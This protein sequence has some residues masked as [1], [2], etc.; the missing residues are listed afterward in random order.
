LKTSNFKI[1]LQCKP[2]LLCTL[3]PA[4]PILS[5]CA[6]Q[7]VNSGRFQGQTV[8]IIQ[9]PLIKPAPP[10]YQQPARKLSPEQIQLQLQATDALIKAGNNNAAQKFAEAL[11]PAT[12]SPRQRDQLNLF[13]A[14]I[15][16][17]TGE[18]EQALNRLEL[19][20]A[21]QLNLDNKIK[22]FQ[23]QAF[24]FSLT[25]HLLNSVRSRIEL[26]KLLSSPDERDDNQAAIIETLKLMPESALH[27]Q[28]HTAKDV[29]SGWLSLAGLLKLKERDPISFNVKLAKWR[30]TFPGHP[31]NSYLLK[32]M[33]DSMTSHLVSIAVLL[34]ESGPF[35]Q[36]A[37]AIRAGI[38]AAYT[39][40]DSNAAKPA[41]RFYDTEYSTAD[42]LYHQAVADGAELIIGPLRKEH[43]QSLADSV[44]FDIPVLALNH[45]EGLQKNNLYQ[46]SLSP[47]DDVEQI[48]RKA[49]HDG[50]QKALL[51]IPETVQGKRIADYFTEYWQDFDHSILESQTY[52][53]K[54]TDF[55]SAIKKLLNLDESENRYNRLRQLI[56]P[57]N[58][59]PRRR[60]DADVILLSAY[61]NEA[62]LINPQLHYYQAADLPVYALPAIYTGQP[63]PSLD[64]DLNKIT[65]CDTPWLLGSDQGKLSMS[66]LHDTWRQF[67]SSYLR[68]IAMGID[69]YNLITQLD[70]IDVIPYT[71]A[72]GTLSLMLDGRIKRELVCARFTE[73]RPEIM[74]IPTNSPDTSFTHED[75]PIQEALPITEYAD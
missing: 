60:Q 1:R 6:M 65:F 48:T 17:S 4:F 19:I 14:Q 47:M 9:D 54:D 46:F 75:R 50:H 10:L 71:G 61:G 13:Y 30:E 12:M 52:N 43:I 57:I 42:A 41:I 31:A 11:D 3:L 22:Y 37:K 33:A 73:G 28:S 64:Q 21:Q 59:T 25:G 40:Q 18:A 34:P 8:P 62:R 58:F 55:S 5:G 49:L 56:P 67:P 36:A 38:M 24:A 66:A 29:L 2:L 74:D 70:K 20:Q 45:I 39:Y 7:S 27:N 32:N 44:V 51:L 63:N 35:A 16:L 26:G 53:R 72:T 15:M 68:L 23:S 69:A